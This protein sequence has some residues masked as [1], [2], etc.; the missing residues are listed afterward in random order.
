MRGGAG[1]AAG[2]APPVRA[3]S[4]PSGGPGPAASVERTGPLLAPQ[5]PAAAC[6]AAMTRGT[7]DQARLPL[8]A[9]QRLAGRRRAAHAPVPP[10]PRGR[11]ARGGRGARRAGAPGRG[12]SNRGPSLAGLR[13][14]P[15]PVFGSRPLPPHGQTRRACWLAAPYQTPPPHSTATR[16]WLRW[17]LRWPTC[18]APPSCTVSS[19]R[20]NQV[21]GGAP[22]AASSYRPWPSLLQLAAQRS[23]G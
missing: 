9:L 20:Q 16:C 23:L 18:T 6:S 3:R 7:A 1:A 22:A 8:C 11:R 5:C 4:G 12:A 2:G 14:L 19:P 10:R 15:A 17:R 21:A 13:G